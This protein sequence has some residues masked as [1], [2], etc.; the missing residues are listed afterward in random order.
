M[1]FEYTISGPD[2]VIPVEQPIETSITL[3][4]TGPTTLSLLRDFVSGALVVKGV[5]TDLFGCAWIDNPKAWWIEVLPGET[6]E[7]R[8][9]LP[10]P[11]LYF[12]DETK[13][14]SVDLGVELTFMFCTPD[15][16][17]DDIT[18]IN[19]SATISARLSFSHIQ[20][21]PG[22][23]GPSAFFKTAD[24]V[25]FADS[26]LTTGANKASVHRLDITPEGCRALTDV[27]LC[28]DKKM[29]WH[30]WP[31]RRPL[32]ASLRGL[33]NVFYG[34]EQQIWTNYG[35]AKVKDPAS[36]EVFG[37][38]Q[39]GLYSTPGEGGYRCA[40]GRDRFHA[41]F[42]CE[43]VDTKHAKIVR[44][45]KK[46]ASFEALKGPWARDDRNV[47]LEGKVVKGADPESIRQINGC[48][49]VDKKGLWYF[50]Q[51]VAGVTGD[52]S[53]ISPLDGAGEWQE[54]KLRVASQLIDE[55][56]LV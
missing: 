41:Y 9:E 48:Y 39:P 15:E 40:Y 54:T 12:M 13:E 6:I 27:I 3:T 8:L 35:D 38:A 44:S 33:N 11:L 19:K 53:R 42:F 24:Q 14:A 16:S 4:N 21:I 55:G 17:D 1:L 36:F 18:R 52:L 31:K 47:Y 46:P 2:G 28:N 56:E 10:S 37:A 25:F 20:N 51:R 50:D 7:A 49:A 5:L 34:D 29:F 30:D 43:S 26:P 45:C 23:E 22:P 32:R